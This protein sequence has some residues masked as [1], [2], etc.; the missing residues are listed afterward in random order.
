VS[1]AV[2]GVRLEPA[3]A[4]QFSELRP[5]RQRGVATTLEEMV[6]VVEL[7]N[8]EPGRLGDER[9]H[10]H[11]AGVRVEYSIDSHTGLLTVHD[12]QAR[13]CARAG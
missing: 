1:A 8:L 5:D 2:K 12:L 11:A 6:A 3:A 10:L 13:S 9:L 4:R 7:I